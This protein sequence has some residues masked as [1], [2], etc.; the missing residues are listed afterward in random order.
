MMAPLLS[1]Q[2]VTVAGVLV[3]LDPSFTQTFAGLMVSVVWFGALTWL[4]LDRNNIGSTGASAL[5]EA[6]KVNGALTV[7]GVDGL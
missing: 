4:N 2:K 3:F 6:L 5:A 1:L 7:Y